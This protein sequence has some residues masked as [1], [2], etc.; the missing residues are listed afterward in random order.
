MKVMEVEA[1]VHNWKV[2]HIS[3]K[4]AIFTQVECM[5]TVLMKIRSWMVCIIMYIYMHT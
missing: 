4:I 1:F 3:T 5:C 2:G